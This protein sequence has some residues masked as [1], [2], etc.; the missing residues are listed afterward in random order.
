MFS[1]LQTI[2]AFIQNQIHDRFS[3]TICYEGVVYQGLYDNAFMNWL[4]PNPLSKEEIK[5]IQRAKSN[6]N[7]KLHN[8]I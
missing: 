7:A 8:L 6:I 2:K 3:Y 4:N 5:Q 1:K